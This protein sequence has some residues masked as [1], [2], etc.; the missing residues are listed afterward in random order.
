MPAERVPLRCPACLE[1]PVREEKGYRC[2]ACGRDF[3]IG[4]FGVPDFRF[5]PPDRSADHA[6]WQE[7]IQTFVA[8]RRSYLRRKRRRNFLRRLLLR[9]V[10]DYDLATQK[11]LVEYVGVR[12]AVVEVGCGPGSLFRLAPWKLYVGVDPMVYF[13]KAPPFPFFRA[14]G[15]HLPFADDAFDAVLMAASFD[16]LF[17]PEGALAT[18]HRVLRPGGVFGMSLGTRPRTTR[19]TLQFMHYTQKHLLELVGRR[20]DV[21]YELDGDYIYL[22][23]T[24]R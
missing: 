24:P 10:F 6:A 8:W 5:V 1:K 23:G 11:R 4:R 15:E 17:D 22:K 7:M 3:P 12:G 19:G 20:F 13:R 2:S 9:P 16:Y 21:E 18:F 14:Y